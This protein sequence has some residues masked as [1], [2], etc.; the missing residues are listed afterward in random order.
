MTVQELPNDRVRGADAVI[1]CWTNIPDEVLLNNPQLRYLGFWTNLVD[2]R[3]NTS[4]AR[5][6]GV[7]I[8]LHPRLWDGFG[9]GDD[10]HG[11]AGHQPSLNKRGIPKREIG[12]YELLK[13]GK[14]VPS[15]DQIPQRMLH[16]K[17]LGI[18][19]F[20]QIGQRVASCRHFRMEVCYWSRTRREDCEQ[21]GVR[22][23]EIDDLFSW[24]E[25][26]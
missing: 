9:R 22:F 10:L 5:E 16:G 25:T 21:R 3:V 13:T 6:R 1:T 19:G 14:R 24:A 11:L 15:I 26:S 20:G 2:H 8:H 7:R 12:A 4:L 23:M 18:L 17:R